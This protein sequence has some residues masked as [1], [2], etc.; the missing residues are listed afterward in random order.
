MYHINT[1]FIGLIL[2][3]I[4]CILVLRSRLLV[5][6][7]NMITNNFAE[8]LICVVYRIKF[9]SFNFQTPTAKTDST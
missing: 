3:I 2:H 1:L 6:V 5:L 8:I 7:D 4:F 9:F